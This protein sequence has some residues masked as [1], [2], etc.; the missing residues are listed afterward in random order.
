MATATTWSARPGNCA[1]ESGAAG[2]DDPDVLKLAAQAVH[3]FG[4]A[5]SGDAGNTGTPSGDDFAGDYR[6]GLGMTAGALLQPLANWKVM[7]SATWL[8]YRWGDAGAAIRWTI[9][10]NLALG[11]DWALRA[12]WRALEG[13]HEFEMGLRIYF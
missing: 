9:G 2:S 11:R 4:Q 1:C 3:D 8:D 6:A 13:A 12:D 10:Q 5:G 7:A